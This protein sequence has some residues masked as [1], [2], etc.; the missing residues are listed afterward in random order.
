[1]LNA[2]FSPRFAKGGG[3]VLP[4]QWGTY[5]TLGRQGPM[6][7]VDL[8]FAPEYRKNVDGADHPPITMRRERNLCPR[9]PDTVVINDAAK[10]AYFL[11]AEF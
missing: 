10:L 4:E 9:G 3:E 2:T 6:Q 11:N 8:T 5:S 1:M 7:F